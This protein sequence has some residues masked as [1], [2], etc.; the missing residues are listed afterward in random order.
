MELNYGGKKACLAFTQEDISKDY[1][2][3]VLDNIKK[4][5]FLYFEENEQLDI[6]GFTLEVKPQKELPES[7]QNKGP[8]F[9]ISFPILLN[10]KIRALINIS[11]MK[12]HTF[13]S[14]EEIHMFELISKIL[15]ASWTRNLNEQLWI[16][17]TFLEKQQI[18]QIALADPLTETFNRRAFYQIFPRML[19]L[20]FQKE[21]SMCLAM[22]DIDNFK[23]AN[24]MYG[25]TFGDLV[26]KQIVSRIKDQLDKGDKIFRLGGDE[27]AIIFYE[28]D[29]DRA[30]FKAEKILKSVY[31]NPITDKSKQASVSITLSIGIVEVSSFENL[32]V[33]KAVQMADEAL[34]WAKEV[35]KNQ[36]FVY[37]KGKSRFIYKDSF[38]NSAV[39]T[40]TKDVDEK[41]KQIAV[42][43]L[44]G[45][46]DAL[47]H[48]DPYT[49]MHCT[50]ASNCAVELGKVL[51][52][53]QNKLEILRLGGL[54][55]DIGKVGI[56]DNILLKPDKLT[57]DEYRIIKQHTIIGSKI[58]ERFSVL[59]DLV[60]L[61]LCHH[62]RLDGK[63]YPFGLVGES[64]PWLARI[65][66]VADV[67]HALQSKRPY[68]DALSLDKTVSHLL[69]GR[70]KSF[71][72]RAVDALLGLLE[73]EPP[74]LTKEIES[75]K[76][77]ETEAA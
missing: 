40:L 17:Q 37:N 75:S 5:D 62:E 21:A 52:L 59:R 55:H 31:T 46:L 4:R 25:H 35:G 44:M 16:A 10:T 11:K 19:S 58:I 54:L 23:K 49:R 1:I 28:C 7:N 22:I 64:I 50:M 45:L 34:Y 36:I 39:S 33:D 56:P 14:E 72:S 9:D 70:G 73:K 57:G 38:L 60:P 76:S 71:D 32:D 20:M 65:F 69:D 67:F 68:R 47:Y 15:S 24:D 61:I 6:S 26:L 29:K 3:S 66:T 18:E 8:K 74:F 12:T 2:C 27:I 41:I 63:G 13:F 42:E 30:R 48:R 51:S 43:S 77:A 53:E